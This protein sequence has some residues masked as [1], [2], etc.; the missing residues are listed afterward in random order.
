[1]L[2]QQNVEHNRQWAARPTT[3]V[4]LPRTKA[5]PQPKQPAARNYR[6]DAL[7]TARVAAGATNKQ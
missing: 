3:M 7:F 4:Q 6:I 2:Q 1:M 5:N